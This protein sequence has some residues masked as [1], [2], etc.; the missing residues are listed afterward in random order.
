MKLLLSLITLWPLLA[1]A[2]DPVDL[3]AELMQGRSPGEW[4]GVLNRI[5]EERDATWIGEKLGKPSVDGADVAVGRGP[6]VCTTGGG[7]Q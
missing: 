6:Y 3:F 5:L 4:R 7:D 2:Q 1:S